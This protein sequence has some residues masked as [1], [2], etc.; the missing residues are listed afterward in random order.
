MLSRFDTSSRS[1]SWLRQHLRA[2]RLR[3][4]VTFNP[5]GNTYL[6]APDYV[7]RQLRQESPIHFSELLN[8]WIVTRYQDI[9]AILRDHVNFSSSP[10]LASQELLDPYS[11]LDPEN[12]SL[13]M[14]DPPDHTRLRSLLQPAFTNRN[15]GRLTPR[16]EQTIHEA[17]YELR[18]QGNEIDFVSRFAKIIPIRVLDI[19]MGTETED[20]QRVG[21]WADTIVA[22][23]EPIATSQM[24]SDAGLA[25]KDLKNHLTDQLIQVGKEGSLI[26]LLRTA[27]TR[28]ALSRDEAL[29]IT[30][31]MFLA[32]SKTVSDF[33][34]SSFASLATSHRR[35]DGMPVIS[36]RVIDDLLGRHAPVQMLARTVRQGLRFRDKTFEKGQRVLLIL[37]SGNDDDLSGD[38]EKRRLR[39]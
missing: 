25:Y 20:C 30:I 13:F 12:P 6:K 22:A 28:R 11:L 31:F 39:Q 3:S 2:E 35:E 38:V 17:V 10:A 14:V 4:G 7:Y 15:I 24:A 5:F 9:D 21:T 29:Q 8:C 19:L 23:M 37:A 33:I 26:G 1:P 34:G 32:G 18:A 36:L 27:V 16:I